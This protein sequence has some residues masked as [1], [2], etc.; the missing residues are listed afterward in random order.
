MPRR[1]PLFLARVEGP[2]DD[3]CYATGQFVGETQANPYDEECEGQLQQA[4]YRLDA[5]PEEWAVAV[6]QER[7]VGVPDPQYT[8]YFNRCRDFGTNKC[9]GASKTNYDVSV[10]SLDDDSDESSLER[11]ALRADHSYTESKTMYFTLYQTT[12]FDDMEFQVKID[13]AWRCCPEGR[14]G[15][16]ATYCPSGGGLYHFP[17]Y[18]TCNSYND[19]DRRCCTCDIGT[20][21]MYHPLDVAVVRLQLW[22]TVAHQG[23]SSRASHA[24]LQLH[25][26]ISGDDPRP[27]R[28]LPPDLHEHGGATL[29]RKNALD[30]SE[31]PKTS[32]ASC[33]PTP[34]EPPIPPLPPFPPPKPPPPPPLLGAAPPLLSSSG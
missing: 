32:G 18:Y 22:G 25:D 6:V 5:S 27:I 15:S 11:V 17:D 30:F 31:P 9:D 24:E 19:D 33:P 7:D 26:P 20:F 34:P 8:V 12:C 14:L 29:V 21:C 28:H 3:A 23:D 4:E 2:Y 13:M 1:Q 10:S 16:R